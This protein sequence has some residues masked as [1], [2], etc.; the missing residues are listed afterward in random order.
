M[1]FDLVSRLLPNKLDYLEDNYDS[2]VILVKEEAK[3]LRIYA[4]KEE[5]ERLDSATLD[6]DKVSMCVYGQMTGN[7]K[8]ERSM[9]LIH[10]CCHRVYSSGC[11]YTISDSKLNGKPDLLVDPLRRLTTYVSPIE[12]FILYNKNKNNAQNNNILIDYLKGNTN[13]LNFK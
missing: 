13:E 9:K 5:I 3:K 6:A 1:A 4:T 10:K 11:L 2:L 7:C 12:K 8:N